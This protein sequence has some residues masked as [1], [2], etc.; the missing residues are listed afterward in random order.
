MTDSSISESLPIAAPEPTDAVS[1]T[2]Q[3]TPKRSLL[4]R[5][6]RAI[7]WVL[8]SGWFGLAAL[9]VIGQISEGGPLPPDFRTYQ[10]AAEALRAG[11]TPYPTV[12]AARQNWLDIHALEPVS[13]EQNSANPIEEIGSYVY[14]PTLAS[15]FAATGGDTVS[16]GSLMTLLLLFST[17]AFGVM[18]LR[19]TNL[20]SWWLLL[21]IP[22]FEVLSGITGGNIEAFLLFAALLSAWLMWRGRG[23]LATPLIAFIAVTKPFYALFFVAFG[24]LLLLN[25]HSDKRRAFLNLLAVG[26]VSFVFIALEVLRWGPELQAEALTYIGNSL[27][28]LWFALPY[29]QQS[30]LSLWNRTLMQG[31]MSLGIEARPAQLGSLAVWLVLLA[32]TIWRLRNRALTFPLVFAA[33]LVLLYLGRPVGWGLVYLE[34]IVLAV[35]WKGLRGLPRGLVLGAVIGLLV[36]RWVALTLTAQG[37]WLNLMTM[38]NE[39]F[40]WEVWLVL[41]AAWL[42]VV[43]FGRGAD[44]AVS[45]PT[46]AYRQT[47][48]V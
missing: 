15:L 16:N 24:L 34:V 25:R 30:P 11:E 23:L 19:V 29:E 47:E 1:E 31:L 32:V 3:Q 8:F 28:Y 18:W 20:S 17:L 39:A 33:A 10:E 7:P 9:A 2:A 6:G 14:L 37:V 45:P 21:I 44:D 22:S 27:D 42:L 40:L 13:L 5:I 12:E 36:S 26:V 48:S 4:G 38:Q 35:A 41:P 43:W 46:Y